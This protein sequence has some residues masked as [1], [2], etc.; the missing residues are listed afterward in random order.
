MISYNEF[1]NHRSQ[2]RL[3]ENEVQAILEAVLRQLV[4]IHRQG[5]AYQQISLKTLQRKGE[6]TVLLPEGDSN[7]KGSPTKDIYDLG[8][9]ALELLT[10]Q[11]PSPRRTNPH[12]DWNDHC[13]V[14]DQLNMVLERM[15]TLEPFQR[16][17]NASEVLTAMGLAVPLAHPFPKLNL[18]KFLIG[19]LFLLIITSLG[20]LYY[21]DILEK[22]PKI[23]ILSKTPRSKYWKNPTLKYSNQNVGKG[24]V[25]GLTPDDQY[26][27][28]DS[29]GDISFLPTNLQGDVTRILKSNKDDSLSD[30]S[31]SKDGSVIV[32]TLGEEI[33]IRGLDG[34]EVSHYFFGDCD[35]LEFSISPDSKLLFIAKTYSQN[36][37]VYNLISGTLI[38]AFS[39]KDGQV[40]EEPQ[41]LSTHGGTRYNADGHMMYC[42]ISASANQITSIVISPNGEH[43]AVSDSEGLI[44]IWDVQQK[45]LIQTLN[46]GLP[47]NNLRFLGIRNSPIYNLVYGSDSSLIISK[48]PDKIEF[49]DVNLNKLI[50]Q[51]SSFLSPK[52]HKDTIKTIA[53]SKDNKT[54]ASIGY[55]NKLMIWDLVDRR[56]LSEIEFSSL[57]D[58][59]FSND[60]Q[61]L[62]GRDDQGGIYIWE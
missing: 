29:D 54:L 61:K 55:D 26:I 23:D 44:K 33:F 10:G 21:L 42:E 18:S 40:I 14:S 8:L 15:V 16:L 43:L 6:Q 56:L 17:S 24:R 1:L 62:F 49:W 13:L 59:E 36:I 45:R 60:G 12:W 11:V 22:K 39:L 41:P 31:I 38:Y 48:S 4:P 50:G 20:S 46:Q 9:V 58:I 34:N 35:G 28:F 3:S 52:H 25:M 37:Y 27:F 53:L 32:F 47:W 57:E 30:L 2:K 7:L 5:K 51:F 19:S